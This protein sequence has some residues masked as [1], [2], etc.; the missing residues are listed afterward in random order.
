MQL[1]KD[2]NPVKIEHYDTPKFKNILKMNMLTNKINN[3]NLPK[4]IDKEKDV[5]LRPYQIK[6]HCNIHNAKYMYKC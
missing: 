6:V 2:N 4:P 5:K 1:L 3:S